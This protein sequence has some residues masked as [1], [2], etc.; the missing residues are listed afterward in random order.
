MWGHSVDPMKDVEIPFNFSY[1]APVSWSHVIFRFRDNA[2]DSDP[3]PSPCYFNY[4]PVRH[5]SHYELSASK[6]TCIQ[7]R[8]VSTCDGSSLPHFEIWE[9]VSKQVANEYKTLNMWYTNLG[10]HFFL[11]ISSTNTDSLVPLLY[12]CV[13]TRSTEA[14]LTAVSATSAPPFQH[15]RHQ[16]NVWR[17]VVNRFTGQTL[18]TVNRKHFFMNIFCIESFRPQKPHSRTLF[19]G[20]RPLK[21]GRH[22]DY[23][24]QRWAC[25]C[26]CASA[27]WTFLF[28][29][30]SFICK[31]DLGNAHPALCSTFL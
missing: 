7:T 11:D 30:N 6:W 8:V 22:F 26:A 4:T 2:H 10:K 25:A 12:Q 15:L 27:T 31:N 18:P 17:P 13:E 16:R 9:R 5:S 21:H 20:S 23:Q 24:N 28:L 1:E 14:F 19:L 3:P 29:K